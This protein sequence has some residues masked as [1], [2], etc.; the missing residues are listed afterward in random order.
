MSIPQIDAEAV[1]LNGTLKVRLIATREGEV[2][3]IDELNAASAAAR[4]RYAD[5]T[6]PLFKC[7]T[8]AISDILH[9][10]CLDAMQMAQERADD[11][12]TPARQTASLVDSQRIAELAW[13]PNGPDFIV[14][15]R[16]TGAV[17]RTHALETATGHYG[18]PSICAGIVT[19]GGE[20]PGNVL[21]PTQ[22]ATD[23]ADET[24]LRADVASF[25]G[26][27]VE[28]P[29]DA[30]SLAVE[31]VLLTWVFDAF[32]EVPY[33]AFRTADAGRGKSRAL[34]TVASVCYRSMFVGGGSSAAA[35][36]RMLHEFGGTLAADEFD[37]KQNT[38][39]AWTLT[40]ILNQ[41]FQRNRPLIKCDGD[42][43]EPR[44]FRCFGPKLFAL[45]RGFT[46][47]ATESRT[48][49]VRMRQRTRQDI[50]LNLPRAAFDAE[51]VAL[52][53]RLLGW[54]FLNL[55]RITIRPDLAD[56][57]LED[58]ANQIGLP[59]LSIAR[60]DEDRARIVAV[61]GER[62]QAIALDRAATLAGEI[63]EVIEAMTEPDD[64]VRP[65]L[66][67]QEVNR[68]RAAAEGIEIGKLRKPA[69][70]HRVGRVICGELELPQLPK[71]NQGARYQYHPERRAELCARYGVPLSETSLS[72]Y[73]HS[74]LQTSPENPLFDSAG[75]VS[76]VSD[77]GDVSQEGGDL[78]D[79]SG[80][81]SPPNDEWAK[82]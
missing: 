30:C 45:R 21:V 49:N 35:T 11:V 81:G 43:L 82:R 56:P 25:I 19:P 1:T 76:D 9:Q 32:D 61:L 5:R 73:R 69:T 29:G 74:S 53:N 50:P 2:I 17:T 40:A 58:R 20:I 67:A 48:L 68:R 23:A 14:F 4:K 7:T 36:L 6:A 13:G 77:V 75:G 38:E 72:S 27:Y 59:L 12:A 63:V 62:Q 28:L 31:Y 70:A 33:L 65:G 64:D 54:R 60:T 44:A 57:A 55:D 34:D 52:R 79:D 51:A 16:T 37:L 41:G 26:R 8:K 10:R 39:L 22:A 71:D 18:L 47:D 15:D 78:C 42:A 46:D 3:D 66:V 80:L 24:G